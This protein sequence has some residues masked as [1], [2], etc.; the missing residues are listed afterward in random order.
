MKAF[1]YTTLKDV[2][3]LSDSGT[4]GNVLSKGKGCPALRSSDISGYKLDFEN[5]AYVEIPERDL[6]RKRLET[7]D[8]IITKSSGSSNLVGKCAI[9]YPPN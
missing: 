4:W 1:P 8:I 7:G 3:V 5:V 9:F 6:E 2:L